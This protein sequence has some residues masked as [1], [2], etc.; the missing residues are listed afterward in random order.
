MNAVELFT[1][2][3]SQA[4]ASYILK[5]H[6]LGTPLTIMELSSGSTTNMKNILSYMKKKVPNV[7]KNLHYYVLTDE[8]S[9]CS[10]LYV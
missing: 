2:Y 6:K 10:F 9:L 7:Y 5:E 3:F 1:P 8:Y 4:I